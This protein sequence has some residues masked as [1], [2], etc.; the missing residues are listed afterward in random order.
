MILV[1]A[2][3]WVSWYLVRD[4]FHRV[5]RLWV[6]SVVAH[7]QTLVIPSLALTETAGAVARRTGRSADGRRAARVML[8]VPSIRVDPVDRTFAL[9]A[10]NLAA[11]LKLRGPDAVYVALAYQLGVPLVTWDHEQAIRGRR[12]ITVLQPTV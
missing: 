7:G 3:V 8:R 1:D 11:S 12:L 2:S 10:A 5:S 6:A 4:A 9:A